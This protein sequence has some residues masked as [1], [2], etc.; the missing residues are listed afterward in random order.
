[1]KEVNVTIYHHGSLFYGVNKAD[2]TLIATHRA[3]GLL[4]L[5]IKSYIK[6]LGNNCHL[7]FYDKEGKLIQSDHIKVKKPKKLNKNGLKKNIYNKK[8]GA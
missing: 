8:D 4:M 5:V 6:D 1:M 3:K 7:N 2:N